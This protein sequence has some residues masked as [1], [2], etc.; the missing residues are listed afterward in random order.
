MITLNKVCKGRLRGRLRRE[1]PF[2]G[3]RSS[4]A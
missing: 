2:L 1:L 3:C 4:P